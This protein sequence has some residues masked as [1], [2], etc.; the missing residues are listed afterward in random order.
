[1]CALQATFK[2]AGPWATMD[3][4]RLCPQVQSVLTMDATTHQHFSAH[5]VVRDVRKAYLAFRD[6]RVVSTGP[7]PQPADGM[8]GAPIADRL[9]GKCRVC[10]CVCPAKVGEKP[11]IATVAPTDAR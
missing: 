10:V 4:G 8:W 5:M 1:M 6:A 3:A 9:R 7:S 2:Y 11:G